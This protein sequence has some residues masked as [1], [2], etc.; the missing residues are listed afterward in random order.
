MDVSRFLPAAIRVGGVEIGPAD[1]L[2][3]ALETLETGADEVTVAPREQL[4]G[5]GPFP[6]MKKMCY[7][8]TWLHSPEFKDNYLSD[9]MRW[10]I[11]TLRYE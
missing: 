6:F 1:F 5:F 9:R 4:G 3:A 8:G 11:W 2:F 10:Q 7:A